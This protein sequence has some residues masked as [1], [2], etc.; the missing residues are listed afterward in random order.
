MTT[1]LAYLAL[2]VPDFAKTFAQMITDPMFWLIVVVGI[3]LQGFLS[4]IM[5]GKK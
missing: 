1:P 5:E 4:N 3:A 2:T